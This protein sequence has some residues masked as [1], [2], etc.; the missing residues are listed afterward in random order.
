MQVYSEEGFLI[1]Y[2][3]RLFVPPEEP[4]GL[5]PHQH[6]R[7]LVVEDPNMLVFTT[8]FAIRV[9]ATFENTTYWPAYMLTR[10]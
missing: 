5:S 6:H 1:K 4:P 2:Q 3:E 7:Q 10:L 8:V 9:S